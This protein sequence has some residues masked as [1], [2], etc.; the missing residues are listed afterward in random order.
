MSRS[1]RFLAGG[2]G[3][4]HD[5]MVVGA[6]H[7]GLVAANYLANEGLNVLVVE[8]SAEIGGMTMTAPMIAEAPTIS[9]TT[10]R[11]I[12]FCG[13]RALRPVSWRSRSMA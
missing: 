10:A 12:P 13:A 1:S 7:N 5:M 2:A 4:S 9:S 11:L 8:A 6:G 3:G